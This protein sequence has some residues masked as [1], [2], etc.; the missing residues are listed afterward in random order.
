MFHA[1][2]AP[3][4]TGD[5]SVLLT[6]TKSKMWAHGKRYSADAEAEVLAVQC[7]GK[8]TMLITSDGKARL[9]RRKERQ[10]FGEKNV[11]V[12][13][14]TFHVATPFEQPLSVILHVY[15]EALKTVK[16]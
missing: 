12:S 16:A 1:T 9:I 3:D 4:F 13:G 11:Y 7:T 6:V 2:L 5:G 8:P 10:A 14:R 15:E